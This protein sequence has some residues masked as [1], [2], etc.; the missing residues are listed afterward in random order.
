[1]YKL[2]TLLDY[3]SNMYPNGFMFFSGIFLCL[4]GALLLQLIDSI[5]TDFK[6]FIKN[7]KG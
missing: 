4:L 2:V 3:L 7:I 5:I 1:M 6:N